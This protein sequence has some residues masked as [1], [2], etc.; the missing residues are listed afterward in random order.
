MTSSQVPLFDA[1]TKIDSVAGWT[2]QALCWS[3][4]SSCPPAQPAYPTNARINFEPLPAMICT[5]SRET[6]E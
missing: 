6:C 4:D 3:S 5:C 2:I 1:L